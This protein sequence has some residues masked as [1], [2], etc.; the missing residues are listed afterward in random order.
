MKNKLIDQLLEKY[1]EGETNLEEEN[2]LKDYFTSGE[3]EKN[4]EVYSTLFQFYTHE[5]KKV[6]IRTIQSNKTHSSRTFRKLFNQH[7]FGFGI[8]AS[9]LLLFAVIVGMRLSLSDNNNFQDLNNYTYIDENYDVDEAL[10]LT[11]E[12]LGFLT[13]KIQNGQATVSKNLNQVQKID[14]INFQ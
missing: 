8:A 5:Q 7:R 13:G 10:A 6:P 2:V 14:V 3:I 12:A 1:W 4:H 11:T 9:L